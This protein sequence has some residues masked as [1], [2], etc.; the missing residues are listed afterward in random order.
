MCHSSYSSSCGIPLGV[1]CMWRRWSRRDEYNRHSIVGKRGALRDA[2][3]AAGGVE[4]WMRVALNVDA[5]PGVPV[6]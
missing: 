4:G 3:E 2:V 6:G 5:W 1:E